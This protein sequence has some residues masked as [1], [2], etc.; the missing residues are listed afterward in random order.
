MKY[1][2]L[3][4]IVFLVLI[5]GFFYISL[6]LFRAPK[7]P[8]V[9]LQ[10]EEFSISNAF[11][12]VQNIAQKPHSMA[13]KE[14]ARV[15]SYIINELLKIG[16]DTLTQSTTA[17][18]DFRG[19][20]SAGYVHNVFGILKGKGK[21][22][23]VLVTA[24]YDSQPH[25]LGAADDG[26]AIA[27]MLEA[28]RAL[29]NAEPLE[30]D[31]IFLFSDGEESGLFGAKA[32]AEQHPLAKKVGIVL[33][34]EA[35]GSSGPS[36]MFEVSNEN[37]WIMKEFRKGVK[38]KVTSSLAYEVY[39]TMSN[40]SDFTI[41]K[42]Y[43]YSGFNAAFIEDFVNYHNI[44][45]NPENLSKRSLYHHGS[46]IMDICKHFG[47]INLEN[48]KAPD[49]VY[50]N[51]A[52]FSFI[53]YP[54]SLNI[55]LIGFLFVL[56]VIAFYLGIKKQKI[57][58][59]KSL[60]S[61]LIVLISIGISLGVV[62]LSQKGIRSTY[63]WYENFYEAN[64]YNVGWYFLFFGSVC[65]TIVSF[66]WS[67]LYKK[68]DLIHL[69]LASLLIT[70]ILLIG[71][72]IYMPTGIYVML[73]PLI[74]LL[75]FFIAKLKFELDK[76]Q[77]SYLILLAILVL[78]V[79]TLYLPLVK[80][81]FITFGLG[82]AIAGS[83]VWVLFLWLM[84]PIAD[85]IMSLKRWVLPIAGIWFAF[86]FLLIAHFKSD[87]TEKRPLQSNV[88]YCQNANTGESFWV[89]NKSYID[90]WNKQF[91]KDARIEAISEIYPSSKRLRLKANA[92][93]LEIVHPELTILR[94]TVI[95][96]LRNLS[97]NIKSLRGA[98]NAQFFIQKAAEIKEIKINER[99]LN[100]PKFFEKT[101]N[102][103]Y[104]FNYYGLYEEGVNLELKCS[105]Q[106]HFTIVMI[107]K[108]LGLP[109]LEGFK[110][111]PGNI[112]PD[113]DYFSNLTVLSK[114]WNF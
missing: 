51:L 7:P 6:A 100:D 14:H 107:E 29:K 74:S 4:Q 92:P 37:G 48:T 41:Y 34:L 56:F 10:N 36:Y 65:I 24:H 94:D 1:S 32:F 68:L 98:E 54:Q 85:I 30:Q 57:R 25:T 104:L 22:K 39:K 55:Y 105:A 47:N 72:Q 66:F 93:K 45:D 16:L 5:L 20:V 79:F 28:A 112:V 18:Y 35:R 38:H 40:N 69:M 2:R 109:Q 106:D 13:T 49:L 23:S 81:L 73:I 60:I 59:W 83:A 75:F 90:S 63:P 82:M 12:H 111:M 44:T 78:P 84:V 43:G 71:L 19:G 9:T 89:S 33:N 87:Y 17:F 27:A 46:Y 15:R 114:T 26:A 102:P 103:F 31:V 86:L 3:S 76:I 88:N 77:W 95:N 61:F 70:F 52:G 53:S 42:D 91:F 101:R 11:H 110:P 21:G 108:K 62:W 64:F 96:E 113:T 97:M 80:I 50:F 58:F 8:L 99:I 67:L